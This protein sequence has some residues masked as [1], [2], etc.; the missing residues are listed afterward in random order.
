M[1]QLAP[2]Q[3]CPECGKPIGRR[4]KQQLCG[5][6]IR[7]LESDVWQERVPATGENKDD[8]PY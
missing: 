8:I 7:K 5:S 6:C 2:K 3:N 1:P 4:W